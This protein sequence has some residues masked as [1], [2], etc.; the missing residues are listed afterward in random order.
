MYLLGDRYPQ[1]VDMKTILAG[2]CA[3]ALSTGGAIFAQDKSTAAKS[4]TDTQ[5]TTTKTMNDKTIKTNTEMVTGQVK[6]Y[7]PGKSISVTVPGKVIKTK[8]FT[9]NSK[10]EIVRMS[11]RIRKGDWVTVRERTDNNG[12]KTVTVSR[13]KR[14]VKASS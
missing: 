8:S 11:S 7:D 14:T 10:G 9:L 2:V 1:E 5:Q 6:S 12:H 4:S 13:A 3:L